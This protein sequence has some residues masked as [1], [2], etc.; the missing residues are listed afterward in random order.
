VTLTDN[1]FRDTM[2]LPGQNVTQRPVQHVHELTCLVPTSGS[3]VTIR[4][5]HLSPTR[6]YSME[7]GEIIQGLAS[8]LLSRRQRLHS[9]WRALTL[10]GH[11]GKWF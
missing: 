2:K 4:L 1:D 10:S 11:V 3:Q 9:V 7:D 5:Q 8:G 6:H